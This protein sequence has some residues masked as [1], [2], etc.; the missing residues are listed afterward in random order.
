[1]TIYSLD[2]LLFLF[3]NSL[4]FHVQFSPLL[5]DLHTGFSRSRSGGLE[6]PSLSEFSSLLWSTQ[7]KALMDVKYLALYLPRSKKKYVCFRAKSLQLCLMFCNPMDCSPPGSSVHG[8]IQSRLLEWVAI[9]FSRGSS[10]LRDGTRVA[11]A[12]CT[13]RFCSLPL[14]PSGKPINE[15]IALVIIW[16]LHRHPSKTVCNSPLLL[17]FKFLF[18]LPF[19]VAN[20]NYL[21]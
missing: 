9:P 1:M 2:V 12:F 13:G 21:S 18:L 20:H 8:I 5:P 10:W 4:L 14:V 17:K 6:F 15:E 3:G 11:Y 19:S 16:V 7:S